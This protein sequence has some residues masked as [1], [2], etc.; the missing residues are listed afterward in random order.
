MFAPPFGQMALILHESK[1]MPADCEPYYYIGWS[2][3]VKEKIHDFSKN[4]P[5]FPACVV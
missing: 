2:A 5:V 3:N 4:P 1:D